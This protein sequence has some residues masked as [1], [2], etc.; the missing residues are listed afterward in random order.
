MAKHKATITLDRNKVAKAAALI[1]LSKM[2]EV[3][4]VAL[5]RLIW[6]EELRSDLVAYAGQPLNEADLALGDLP[7]QL[8]LGDEDIDYE[9]LYGKEP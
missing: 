6:T 9:V 4:D 7:V 8:D 2:S 3:I 1:G 5:D